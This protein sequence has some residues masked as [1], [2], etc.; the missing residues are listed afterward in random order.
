MVIREASLV[1]YKLKRKK[2]VYTWLY[3][4]SLLKVIILLNI[5]QSFFYVQYLLLKK[6]IGTKN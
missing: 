4:T 5:C 6:K 3:W 2:I 1:M